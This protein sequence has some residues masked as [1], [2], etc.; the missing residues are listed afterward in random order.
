M[1][2]RVTTAITILDILAILMTGGWILYGIYRCIEFFEIIYNYIYVT[3][4]LFSLILN[5]VKINSP[6]N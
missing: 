2:D 3:V 4:I 1:H 6:Q 5:I